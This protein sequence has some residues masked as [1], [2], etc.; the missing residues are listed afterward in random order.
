MRPFIGVQYVALVRLMVCLFVKRKS[1]RATVNDAA[2]ALG[3]RRL[4][5]S[6]FVSWELP[7]VGISNES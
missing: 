7:L 5:A 4:E 2:A 3:S 6:L 1:Q